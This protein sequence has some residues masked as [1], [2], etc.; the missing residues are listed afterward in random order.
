M[1]IL[2]QLKKGLSS[3]KYPEKKLSLEVHGSLSDMG[4]I[5]KCMFEIED[6]EPIALID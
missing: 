1:F 2:Y 6:R 5:L 4:G 3:K